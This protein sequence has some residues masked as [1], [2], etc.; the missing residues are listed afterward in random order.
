MARTRQR[1][2]PRCEERVA[3]DGNIISR[4]DQTVCA[5]CKAAIA[6]RNKTPKLRGATLHPEGAQD[7]LEVCDD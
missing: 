4:H 2:W 1:E 6:R 7:L 3:C 5:P